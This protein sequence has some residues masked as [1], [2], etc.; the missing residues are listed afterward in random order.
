[1]QWTVDMG[2]QYLEEGEQGCVGR[3]QNEGFSLASGGLPFDPRDMLWPLAAKPFS[4]LLM[5]RLFHM[6]SVTL[7]ISLARYFPST[8]LTSLTPL[9]CSVGLYVSGCA[10]SC[11]S[12][13]AGKKCLLEARV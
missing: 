6:Q 9:L 8:S 4:L 2:K 3:N 12:I 1:M 10:C 11:L 5:V 7:E 13:H